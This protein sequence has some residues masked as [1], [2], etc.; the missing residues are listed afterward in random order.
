VLSEIAVTTVSPSTMRVKSPKR[1][2]RWPGCS[3]VACKIA[4]GVV[5]G[6]PSSMTIATAHST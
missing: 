4:R 6:V 3:G 5:T 2:G 1:S